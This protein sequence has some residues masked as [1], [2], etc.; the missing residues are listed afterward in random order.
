MHEY[1]RQRSDYQSELRYPEVQW[2][3]SQGTVGFNSYI[4]AVAMNAFQDI[5]LTHWADPLLHQNVRLV[6]NTTIGQ[7]FNRTSCC[8]NI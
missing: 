4:S 5:G 2:R 7:H 1:T 6:W 8:V 3:K